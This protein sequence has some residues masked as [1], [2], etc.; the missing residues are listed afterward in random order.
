MLNYNFKRTIVFISIILLLFASFVYAKRQPISE[1]DLDKVTAESGVS[2]NLNVNVQAAATSLGIYQTSAETEG[3]IIRDI[4]I[5]NGT[6]NTGF[7]VANVVKLDVGTSG[8][9]SWL[10]LDGLVLPSADNALRIKSGTQAAGGN[11]IQVLDYAGANATNTTYTLGTYLD[12]VGLNIGRDVTQAI[13]TGIRLRPSRDPFIR[14]SNHQG[15]GIDVVSEMA[16]Y[17]NSINFWTRSGSSVNG[18]DVNGIYI[19]GHTIFDP[20]RNGAYNSNGDPTLWDDN[21]YPLYGNAKIG[22][23]LPTYTY[24][25]SN[26]SAAFTG[27]YKNTKAT[28]DVGSSGTATVL[29]MDLPGAMSVKIRDMGIGGAGLGVSSIDNMTLYKAQLTIRNT[30]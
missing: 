25:T 17:I 7:G 30:Y 9:E 13:G 12:I 3:I 15:T 5:D 21:R 1:E 4:Y 29:Q 6:N 27:N 22:G 18:L 8:T 26:Y 28:I 10:M 24:D 19:Y 16:V 20:N 2:L 23:S 11:L 14:L